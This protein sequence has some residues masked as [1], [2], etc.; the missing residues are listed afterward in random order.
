MSGFARLYIKAMIKQPPWMWLSCNTALL[1]TSLASC[2]VG[3][4][5]THQTFQRERER[6]KARCSTQ[7]LKKQLIGLDPQTFWGPTRRY[8]AYLAVWVPKG[9]PLNFF[10]AI[11]ESELLQK[12]M[13]PRLCTQ[14]QTIIHESSTLVF[15]L[16]PLQT[17]LEKIYLLT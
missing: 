6:E 11:S 15:M 3:A 9:A 1:C 8:K 10:S 16:L 12:S 13:W 5:S 7:H 17:T 2:S 14:K 4:H